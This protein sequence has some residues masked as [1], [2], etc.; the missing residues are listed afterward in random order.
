MAQRTELNVHART[1]LGKAAKRLRQKGI[2]PANIYGHKKEPQAVQLDAVTFDRLR[3]DHNTRNIFSLHVDDG[4]AQT[5]LIRHVQIDPIS[6][7]VMHIDFARVNLN[8]VITSKIPLNFVGEAPGVK[9][10]GGMLL[11]VLEA[12]EVSCRV[13]ALVESLEVDVS[14]LE[15]L[16][17]TIYARDIAL[18]ANYELG[19]D[20][21]EPVV[22]VAVPRAE[23]AAEAEEVTEAREAAEGEAETSAEQSTAEESEASEQ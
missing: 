20:P 5:A 16:D 1:I 10:E 22:K 14:V 6:Q 9:V 7:N 23:K 2:I 21:D 18:P 13:S 4:P 19:I 17:D 15:H 8:E 12:L 11:R 3:R